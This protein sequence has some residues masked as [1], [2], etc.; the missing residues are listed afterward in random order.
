MYYPGSGGKEWIP[1]MI[2]EWAEWIWRNFALSQ[3]FYQMEKRREINPV[4]YRHKQVEN[5][6]GMVEYGELHTGEI[7]LIIPPAFRSDSY[8][9]FIRF[10][11]LLWDISDPNM[12]DRLTSAGDVNMCSSILDYQPRFEHVDAID[13]GQDIYI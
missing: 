12:R 4:L 1:Y 11:Y 5:D 13:P 10:K 9:R 7:S 2:I 6:P 3:I 8:D